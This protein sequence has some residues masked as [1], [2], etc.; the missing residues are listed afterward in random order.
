MKRCAASRGLAAA[1]RAE[2][3]EE[4]VDI[5][6]AARRMQARAS[7]EVLINSAFTPQAAAEGLIQPIDTAGMDNVGDLAPGLGDNPNLV[8]DGKTYG[9]AW[10]WGLT[11]FAV[12]TNDFETP[13][14]ASRRSGRATTPA[15]W[16]GATT[17]S[18]R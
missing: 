15:A 16:A 14:A 3:R 18:R 11:S 5:L 1:R 12:D 10:V 6:T 17:R 13:R 4:L 9:V 2:Q 8:I 7:S